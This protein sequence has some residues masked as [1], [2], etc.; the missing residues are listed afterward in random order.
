MRFDIQTLSV[1]VAVSSLVFAFASFTVARMIPS[2]THLRDWALGAGLAALSTL[3][4]GLRGNIPEVISAA[5]ANSLLT[6]GFCFLYMG[7]CGLL[8]RPRPGNWLWLM[9]VVALLTLGWYTLVDT[10]VTAR[11]VVVSLLAAPILSLMAWE[12][13]RYDRSLGQTPLRAFH[14]FTALIC[15]AG[16]LLFLSRVAIIANGVTIKD[17]YSS[18]SVLFVA[19]YIWAILFN[20]WFAIAVTLIVGA[21]LLDDL[22]V[23]RDAAQATNV[24][25]GRFLANMSHEIRTPMNA[26][27]GLLSLMQST[28]LNERQRDYTTKT[29]RAAKSLLHLLNDILD[30][31]KVDAGKM[32]LEQVPFS[33]AQLMQDLAVLLRPPLATSTLKVHFELDPALP[34]GVIGDPMRLQQVL[35]NLGA[36]AIKFTPTGHVRVLV[37]PCGPVDGEW[38]SVRFAVEDSGIGIAPEHQAQIFDGFAQAEASTT[39]RFGGTGLGLAIS[40]RLVAL[41]GGN[42]QLQSV[43]GAGSTFSFELRLPVV[44]QGQP[45]GEVVVGRIGRIG[46]TGPVAE[47]RPTATSQDGVPSTAAPLVGMR[48]LVVEDNPINQQVAFELLTAKGALVSLADDGQQGVEAVKLATVP[49]HVVLMDIQ[50]PVLDGYAATRAIRTELNMPHLPIVAMTANAMAVDRE[51]CLAAGMSEHVSKPFDIHALVRLLNR[52]TGFSSA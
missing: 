17:Y 41:M 49:Y 25:K 44:V 27:L 7:T 47:A 15:L 32:V 14:G 3:L 12:F 33:L 28:A 35:L 11:V 48:I 30:F 23:A 9:G 51:A 10:N 21:H 34:D 37:Q 1:L 5:V 40:K 52:V 6:F 2:E 19:P 20:V 26:I 39:R 50:M 4:V 8:R 38:A 43:L 45:E 22:T 36:N 13:W 31:S 29:E 16:A 42:I 18:G 24:A 46:G